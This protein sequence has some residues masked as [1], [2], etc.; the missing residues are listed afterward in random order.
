MSQGVGGKA[1]GER[2]QSVGEIV[3]G[4]PGDDLVVLDVGT[5]GRVY[6]EVSQLLPVPEIDA[7]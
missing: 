6:Y 7:V 5:T 1:V 3:L 2:N 4:E